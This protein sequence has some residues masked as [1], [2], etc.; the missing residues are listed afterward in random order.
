M[1]FAQK[2]FNEEFLVI[3][4]GPETTSG[5]LL[6]L[7]REKRLTSK[8]TFSSLPWGAKLPLHTVPFKK[9]T[10]IIG[11]DSSLAYTAL[12]PVHSIRERIRE[13]LRQVE[14]ENLLSQI[15][16]KHINQCRKDAAE[17]L[18]IDEVDVLLAKSRVVNFTID[19][20][21]VLNPFGFRAQK[22]EALIELILTTRPVYEEARRLS[23]DNDVF[24]T[25]IAHA[26]LSMLEKVEDA[27]INVL[28]LRPWHSSFF[29]R[30]PSPIGY[31]V[32]RGE[33]G[34]TIACFEEGIKEAWGVSRDTARSI[35]EGELRGAY[36]ASTSKF[37]VKLIKI[38]SQM[39]A[40]EMD[41]SGL[42]GKVFL[43]TSLS[44]PF[45]LPL[46][47]RGMVIQDPPLPA[48]LERFGF[49]LGE[50]LHK[51]P[52]SILF[53]WLAPFFESFYDRGQGGLNE[54][55]RNHL[56]WLGAPVAKQERRL[57]DTK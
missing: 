54:W 36:S 47:K 50:D 20:H 11:C 42:K 25:E 3:E 16:G 31:T 9:P 51:L 48:L 44:L 12:I 28:R 43:D 4:I 57:Y 49:T 56:H 30:T 55:L 7:D 46:K 17:A 8:G 53:R 6:S 37:L 2:F 29:V 52:A 13:P 35:Y 22:I 33:L 27:P 15:I 45:A 39:F 23:G 19:G 41:G 10:A 32:T 34:W 26:E 5:V 24:F 1:D 18:G 40:K 38:C 14:L 21:P